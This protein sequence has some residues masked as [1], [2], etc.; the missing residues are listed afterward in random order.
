MTAIYLAGAEVETL[1]RALLDNGANKV[2]YSYYYIQQMRR[3]RFIEQMQEEYPHVQWL[4]DSGGFTYWAKFKAQPERLMKV[5]EYRRRYF[6]YIDATWD[7]W[8]RVTELDVDPTGLATP[9]EVAEWRE[10]MLERWPRANIMPVWHPERGPEEWQVFCRDKRLKHL[11]IGSGQ[12]LWGMVRRMIWEARLRNKTV[13]GFG[14]TKVRTVLP[15]VHYTTVDSTSWLMGQ[16]YGTLF[17]FANNQFRLVG[18]GGSMGKAER[19]FYRKHFEKIGVDWRK[20]EADDVAEVRRANILAWTRLSDR[21]EYMR[22]R[23]GRGAPPENA[24]QFNNL[25]PYNHPE[26][27]ASVEDVDWGRQRDPEELVSH[28]RTRTEEPKPF[29][30]EREDEPGFSPKWG[31]YFRERPEGE[32][33]SG[34]YAKRRPD[35]RGGPQD[36]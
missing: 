24:D 13:H 9:D 5:D 17:V 26:E 16:K 22:K 18:K 19:K 23:Q 21:M 15:S 29:G 25:Y 2:L 14:M 32:E 3:E 30:K 8:A 20:I 33:P 28:L 12:K 34:R 36:T 1:T 35:S 6:S 31:K 7:R 10:E 27:R 4:L 11:A